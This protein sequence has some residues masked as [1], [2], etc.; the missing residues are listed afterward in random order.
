MEGQDTRREPA[1]SSVLE[2]LESVARALSSLE[3]EFG[4]NPVRT[5]RNLL[6]R[7]RTCLPSSV[8][9]RETVIR[10][11][12]PA[13]P[14][15]TPSLGTRSTRDSAAARGSVLVC[16]YENIAV[17]KIAQLSRHKCSALCQDQQ[18]RRFLAS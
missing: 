8:T 6:D 15:T 3:S 2:R 17:L 11:T 16:G 5:E 13:T 14:P 4:D 1:D 9:N 7:L 10:Q 18:L 12:P